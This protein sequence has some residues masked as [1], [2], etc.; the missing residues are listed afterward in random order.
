MGS[1]RLVMLQLLSQSTG[2]YSVHVDVGLKFA[3]HDRLILS[4]GQ[5][6]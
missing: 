1:G 4:T 2:V 6:Y 3:N 5:T